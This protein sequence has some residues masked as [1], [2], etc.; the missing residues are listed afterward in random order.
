M[1]CAADLVWLGGGGTLPAVVS[2]LWA[3][4]GPPPRE[5]KWEKTH[6]VTEDGRACQGGIENQP[7]GGAKSKGYADSK[8]TLGTSTRSKRG[9]AYLSVELP[10][11][12]K[13]DLS[14]G[15]V[16]LRKR[17]RGGGGLF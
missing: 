13:R 1:H 5:M 10:L 15:I 9:G 16:L 4:G 2:A 3:T 8:S 6:N 11:N 14:G 7:G 12:G 17:K